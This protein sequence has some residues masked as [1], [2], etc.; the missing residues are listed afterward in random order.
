MEEYAFLVGLFIAI[1]SH[2]Y[3]FTQQK[4]VIFFLTPMHAFMPVSIC[5]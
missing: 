2:I 3:L 4:L 5:V 1:N